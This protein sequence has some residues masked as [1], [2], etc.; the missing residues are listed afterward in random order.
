MKRAPFLAML[1][2]TGCSFVPGTE[3]HRERL[4][5]GSLARTLLDATSANFQDVKGPI[6]PSSMGGARMLCGEVNAKNA[7]GAYTD[8]RRFA[9]SLDGSIAYVEPDL[10]SEPAD[11]PGKALAEAGA[12]AFR[13]QY[14]LC[15]S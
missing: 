5:R 12:A 7:M 3:A 11:E 4:A 14:D 2:L 9:A 6:G 15:G 10:S 13:S 1:L 8:F